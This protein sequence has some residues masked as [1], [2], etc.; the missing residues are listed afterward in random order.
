MGAVAGDAG[1]RQVSRREDRRAHRAGAMDPVDRHAGPFDPVASPAP[2]STSIRRPA[3][4]V[5]PA[6]GSAACLRD[7]GYQVTEQPVS[8]GRFNVFAQLD[9]PPEVVFSTHFDCVPPFFPSREERGLLFGRGSCDAKGILA[10]QVAAAERLRARRGDA[11]RRCCFVVGEERGSDGAQ[12]RQR[13][14]RRP[15][16]AISSTASRPTTASAPRR[17]A[18]CACDCAPPAAPRTPRSRSSA[19]RRS[20]SCSTR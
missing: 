17:A 9:A 5:R 10:A 3:A 2:W 7:R 14:R 4:R 8:D 12:R 15:A 18:S 19:S 11:H 20:T 16:C 1:D 6:R 13:R